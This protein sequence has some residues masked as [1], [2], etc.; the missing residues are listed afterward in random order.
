MNFD[1]PLR[2][3]FTV[4]NLIPFFLSP[5]IG[6]VAWTYLGDPRVGL[7]NTAAR[8]IGL[9]HGTLFNVYSLYG[10]ITVLGR[11]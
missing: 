10:I 1:L 9:D 7:I 8:S 2:R 11:I 3:T 4:L 5:L 6:S